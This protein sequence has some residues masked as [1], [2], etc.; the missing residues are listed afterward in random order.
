MMH[1]VRARLPTSCRPQDTRRAW[2]PAEVRPG[3]RG[4]ISAHT[5]TALR[6]YRHDSSYHVSHF[7]N[8]YLLGPPTPGDHATSLRVALAVGGTSHVESLA[9][10]SREDNRDIGRGPPVILFI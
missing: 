7:K 3:G 2:C 1:H 8:R 4:R 6:W 9:T 5:A 10:A